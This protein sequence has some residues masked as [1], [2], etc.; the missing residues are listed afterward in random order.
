MIRFPLTY[1][2]CLL[3]GRDF[4]GGDTVRLP[5]LTLDRLRGSRFERIF[6]TKPN[7]NALSSDRAASRRLFETSPKAQHV[8]DCVLRHAQDTEYK[9]DLAAGGASRAGARH[10]KSVVLFS[11]P[12]VAAAMHAALY[13]RANRLLMNT[14]LNVEAVYSETPAAQKDSTIR[15]FTGG[16][17]NANEKDLHVL[18]GTTAAI[19]VGRDLVRASLVILGEVPYPEAEAVQALKRIHR[20]LYLVS[21]NSA[22]HFSPLVINIKSALSKMGTVDKRVTYKLIGKVARELVESGVYRETCEQ[23]KVRP[24]VASV[25]EDGTV[26]AMKVRELAL[27]TMLGFSAAAR[28]GVGAGGPSPAQGGKGPRV[29]ARSIAN[30]LVLREA[31]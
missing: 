13:W 5:G 7:L 23:L 29:G 1:L 2:H 10:G 21:L 25:I 4:N 27:A 28:G 20:A 9:H 24:F 19:G 17:A 26:R 12:I 22:L 11:H 14:R 31:S 15:R 6:A 16:P 30:P 3:G 8:W 18:L